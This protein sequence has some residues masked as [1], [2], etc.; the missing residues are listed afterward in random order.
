[1]ARAG[2][3]VILASTWLLPVALVPRPWDI[4]VIKVDLKAANG[5]GQ[6]KRALAAVKEASQEC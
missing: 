1:M 2:Q 6:H 5:T 4:P 3:G